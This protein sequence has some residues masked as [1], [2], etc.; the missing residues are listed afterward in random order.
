MKTAAQEVIL[1]YNARSSRGKKTRAYAHSLSVHIKDLDFASAGLSKTAWREIL[2]MA[3]L[4]PKDLM[5]KAHPYYQE[6]IR[7]RD[8]DDEGWLDI[9]Q[10]CPEVIRAPIAIKGKRAVVC[11]NPTDIFRLLQ[12]TAQMA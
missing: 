1:Y 8:F 9:L 10:R 7:G 12:G 6:H 5:N 3:D 4:R 11:D 2:V